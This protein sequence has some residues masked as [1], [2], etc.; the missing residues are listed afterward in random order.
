V[1]LAWLLI[2]VVSLLVLIYASGKAIDHAEALVFGTRIP[3]FFVGMTLVAVGTDLPEIAN[4]IVASVADHGDINVG[5]SI[6]SAVTQATLIL[7]LLPWFAG[8]FEV[9][10]RRVILVVGACLAALALG[11]YLVA[12]DYLARADAL[13][14]VLA[15]V[16]GSFLIW[17]GSPPASEPALRIAPNNHFK[18]ALSLLLTLAV[19]GLGAAGA[20]A[21]FVELSSLLGLPEYILSFFLA[22]IGTSMPELF[23][24]VAAL[25]RGLRDLAV[26]DIFGSSFVDATLSIGIG[27]LLAPTMLDGTL[28]VRGAFVALA[29]ILL[30]TLLIVVPGK[31]G[32][33]T[34]VAL[35]LIYGGVYVAVLR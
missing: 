33:V 25:R 3:P 29:A 24:D 7:G 14:L 26:G 15:W 2:L 30:A 6:G 23:V 1:V 35:M 5:D 31:H 22:S 12:D 34:G 13:V 4:S 28:A 9:S 27:P 18:H 20:V 17:L 32:R 21:A 19:V 16:A 8:A 10:R 11:A